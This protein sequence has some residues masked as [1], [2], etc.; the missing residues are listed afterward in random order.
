MPGDN[1]K[2]KRYYRRFQKASEALTKYLNEVGDALEEGGY[3]PQSSDFLD[4]LERLTDTRESSRLQMERVIREEEVSVGPVV[5]EHRTTTT[6][7]GAYLYKKFEDD[8]DTRDSLVEVVYKVKPAVFNRLVKEG[9]IS[10]KAVDKA[11]VA[12][13][14]TT[15]LKGMP[16]KIGLG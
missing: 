14:R 3:I 15:A 11:T 4:D 1:A 9:Q 10:S 6:Y 8:P 12:R 5:V 7:D 13:K 16:S 2:V